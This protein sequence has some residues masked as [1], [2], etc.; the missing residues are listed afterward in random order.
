MMPA[1][2]LNNKLILENYN[3]SI[4]MVLFVVIHYIY[5]GEAWRLPANVWDSTLSSRFF[6]LIAKSF[7]MPAIFMLERVCAAMLIKTPTHRCKGHTAHTEECRSVY[8]AMVSL[9]AVTGRQTTPLVCPCVSF[10]TSSLPNYLS[11]QPSNDCWYDSQGHLLPRLTWLTINIESTM[12]AVELG[13]WL[14]VC[15]LLLT[16]SKI[17]LEEYSKL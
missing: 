1:L 13:R 5:F 3:L 8:Y 11:K 16:N 15:I 7:Q 9:M 4:L 6:L 14:C 10:N 12:W 17:Y 2:T